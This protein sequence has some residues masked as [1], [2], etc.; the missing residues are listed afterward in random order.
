MDLTDDQRCVKKI[1]IDEKQVEKQVENQVEI[2]E[3]KYSK[4]DFYEDY[5]GITEFISDH[6]PFKCFLKQ[7]YVMW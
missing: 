1:K 7:R 3:P 4:R 6:K 2:E 5:V